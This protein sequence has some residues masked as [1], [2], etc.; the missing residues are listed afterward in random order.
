MQCPTTTN[1]AQQKGYFRGIASGFF[2]YHFPVLEQM[3]LRCD[4]EEKNPAKIELKGFGYKKFPANCDITFNHSI[5]YGQHNTNAKTIALDLEIFSMLPSYELLNLEIWSIIDESTEYTE[6]DD[7]LAI[8]KHIEKN[9]EVFKHHKESLSKSKE[10][11]KTVKHLIN[12]ANNEVNDPTFMEN[13]QNAGVSGTDI[14]IIVAM[15]AIAVC[16]GT[17]MY[18]YYKRNDL[19]NGI[20]GVIITY[21]TRAGQHTTPT[22]GEIG[23]TDSNQ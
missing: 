5:Y 18:M 21:L 20:M 14:G 15:A 11:L 1:K 17:L 13:L 9:N 4:N 7:L 12:K 8:E 23:G 6:V 2:I 19:S 16:G 3:E 10:I 22:Q